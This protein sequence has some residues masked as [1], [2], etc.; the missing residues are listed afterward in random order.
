MSRIGNKPV[1]ITNGVQVSLAD[2]IINV[3]GSQGEMSIEVPEGIIVDI[4]DGLVDVTRS[5]N[6]KSTKA[7]HGLI[8]CLIQNAVTG[9]TKTWE[10]KLEV[11]GTGYK[12]KLQG[13]DLVF[14]VGFSH[15]VTF[16]SIENIQFGVQAN[17][18]TISGSDKQKVGQAANK[19][20]SI[21]KPDP[22]KGKGIRYE[23]EFIKLKPG[24][25]AKTA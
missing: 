9:V 4:K 14:D 22:Y 20:K 10:K 21:R 23:G 17:V 6:V 7:L 19:I 13:R 5:N 1:I 18:V 2:S 3:K 12:V 15:S 16:K 11:I 8:R 25:K 24:K